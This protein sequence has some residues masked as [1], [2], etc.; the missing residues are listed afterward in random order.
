MKIADA[1]FTAIDFECLNSVDGKNDMPVQVGIA[2]MTINLN[3]ENKIDR[4]NF[5]PNKLFRSYIKPNKEIKWAENKIYNIADI[6]AEDL[7]NAPSLFELW[8]VLKK[9]LSGNIVV[10]HSAATEKRFLRAFPYHGFSPWVD[11][12]KVSRSAY[13]N[14][15][16]HKLGNM[17]NILKP[18]FVTKLN[19]LCKGFSWHDALYD[20]VASLMILAQIICDSNIFV[21]DIDFLINPNTD[22]YYSKRNNTRF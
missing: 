2:S 5:E 6:K 19:T 22:V 13:P 3:N 1:K 10:A 20:S 21:D 4:F 14:L 16:K 11:S 12:L 18:E 15:A 17:V 7:E 8:N 9:N